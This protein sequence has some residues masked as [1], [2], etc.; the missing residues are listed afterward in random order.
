ML[1]S[2]LYNNKNTIFYKKLPSWR[3]SFLDTWTSIFSQRKIY[4]L[5][6]FGIIFA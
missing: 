1:F 4:G 6:S 3:V 2:Y 5:I